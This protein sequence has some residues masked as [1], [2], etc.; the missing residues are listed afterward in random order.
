MLQRST[1]SDDDDD[2]DGICDFKTVQF[3]SHDLL[4]LHNRQKRSDPLMTE[5]L[6][7]LSRH[8][9]RTYGLIANPRAGRL[10]AEGRGLRH[11]V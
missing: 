4:G 10:R 2:G 1:L 8:I 7:F 3:Y 9:S 11:Q 5:I 6:A